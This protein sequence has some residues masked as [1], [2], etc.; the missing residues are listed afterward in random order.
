MS[1]LY[2]TYTKPWLT[3]VLGSSTW[4][5]CSTRNWRRSGSSGDYARGKSF[6]S[7]VDQRNDV[8]EVYVGRAIIVVGYPVRPMFTAAT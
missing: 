7:E 6:G 5:K 4:I 1:V 8:S 2:L 3:V